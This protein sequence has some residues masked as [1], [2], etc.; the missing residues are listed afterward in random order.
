MVDPLIHP[1]NEYLGL[2]VDPAQRQTAYRSLF[3]TALSD[4][5]LL[6]I[7]SHLQQQRAL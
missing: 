2:G 6:D 5:Q 3:K 4:D 7:R 1:H